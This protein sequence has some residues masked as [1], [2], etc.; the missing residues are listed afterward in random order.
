MGLKVNEIIYLNPSRF[1]NLKKSQTKS[2]SHEI[3][4]AHTASV[5]FSLWL[6]VMEILPAH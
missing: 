6:L 4:K 3:Q 2:G 1:L 5:I